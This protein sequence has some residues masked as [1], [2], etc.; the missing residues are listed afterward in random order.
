MYADSWGEP[1]EVCDRYSKYFIEGLKC[2]HKHLEGT[3][4]SA[5]VS[6]FPVPKPLHVHVMDGKVLITHGSQFFCLVQ[7]SLLVFLGAPAAVGGL[8][9]ILLFIQSHVKSEVSTNSPSDD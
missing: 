4:G 6:V 8:S 5:A 2:S 9:K 7:V 1:P 3:H